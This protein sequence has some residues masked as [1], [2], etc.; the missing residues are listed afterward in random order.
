MKKFALLTGFII[1]FGILIIF[2]LSL[3]SEKGVVRIGYPN[4]P[5]LAPLFIAVDRGLFE[6]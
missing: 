2:S 1:G 6:N 5:L 4:N 3:G